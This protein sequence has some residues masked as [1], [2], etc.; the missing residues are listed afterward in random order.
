MQDKETRVGVLALVTLAA[1]LLGCVT[2]SVYAVPRKK[3]KEKNGSVSPNDPTAR[4]FDILNTSS[5]GKLNDLYLLADVYSDQSNPSQQYQRVLKIDYDKSLYFGRFVIHAR[6]VSKMNG[7]QLAIYN[8]QQIYNFGGRDGQVFD[9]INPGPFGS[10]T[11]DLYLAPPPGGGPLRTV[12]ID[13]S[14]T[15]EY[16]MLVSQYILPAVQKQSAQKQ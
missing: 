14:V 11:G 2:S 13:D 8:S 3:K 12:P 1:I 15:Q 5:G 7:Q 16:E 10:E 6:S 9:K 4:L